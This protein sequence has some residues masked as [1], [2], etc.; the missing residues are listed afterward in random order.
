MGRHCIVNTSA[1]ID[2]DCVLDNYVHVSPGTTIAGTVHIGQN[3]WLGAGST[4]VNNIN[5]CHDVIVGAGSLVIRDIKTSGVY[6]GVPSILLK[7]SLSTTKS[8]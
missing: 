2:H 7:K 4:I 6:V 5:I 3:V 1:S 8:I